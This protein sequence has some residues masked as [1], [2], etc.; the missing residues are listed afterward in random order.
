MVNFWLGECDKDEM[1][2]AASIHVAAQYS[3]V[4][5]MSLTVTCLYKLSLLINRMMPNSFA[6]IGMDQ[7]QILS[8][9]AMVFFWMIQP[10]LAS[11]GL[12]FFLQQMQ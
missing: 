7:H 6:L 11:Q 10:K 4:W 1:L 12:T 8:G 3:T 9:M 2:I 5:L